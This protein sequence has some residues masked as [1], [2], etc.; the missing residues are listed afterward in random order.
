MAMLLELTGHDVVTA[1]SG[2]KAL[3]AAESHRPEFIL[4]DIGLPGMDGYEVAKQLRHMP[5][6]QD[7]VIVAA[8]GY[9]QEEDYSR[10]KAAGF[11]YHLV[12]PIDFNAVSLLLTKI[13]TI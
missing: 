13:R 4:L 3:A 10:T 9:G 1:H 8:S 11:D 7:S 12:K 2:P 6:C 5:S